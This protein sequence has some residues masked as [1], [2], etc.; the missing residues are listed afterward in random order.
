MSPLQRVAAGTVV[1]TLVLAGCAAPGP[2]Q[3][4]SSSDVARSVL[5]GFSI[6]GINVGAAAS[7]ATHA[8]DAM[9]EIPQDEEIAMG[10]DI[11][12]GLLGTAPLVKSSAQEIYVNNV[13][14][15]LALLFA[16]P[17]QPGSFVMGYDEHGRC[18]MLGDHGCTIYEHR[19][20]TCRT[21]DCRVFAATGITPDQPFIAEQVAR[22]QFDDFDAPAAP[23]ADEPALHRALEAL[24]GDGTTLR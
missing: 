4:A 9:R 6:G 22:W 3:P 12:A 19:P 11:A 17:R 8:A 21:Y 10:R 2:S 14:R 16:A 24:R 13:G 15:W 23:P 7:A 5:G 18:P 20:R 1:V